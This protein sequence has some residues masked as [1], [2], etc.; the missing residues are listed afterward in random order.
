[1]YSIQTRTDLVPRNPLSIILPSLR[2]N[3]RDLQDATKVD[4]EPLIVIVVSRA[5][6]PSVLVL[7]DYT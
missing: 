4:L 6:G 7:L 3:F 5:P 1:M 2:I